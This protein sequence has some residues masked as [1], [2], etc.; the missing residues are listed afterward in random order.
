[1]QAG[2]GEDVGSAGNTMWLSET[3]R[4]VMAALTGTKDN[5]THPLFSFLLC[6]LMKVDLLSLSNL[7]LIFLSNLNQKP[8]I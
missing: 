2:E 4:T 6:H 5:P 1:M 8:W 3:Y 7:N